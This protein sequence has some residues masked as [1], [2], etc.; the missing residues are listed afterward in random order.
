ML[1]Y[2]LC[3]LDMA[4]AKRGRGAAAPAEAA[5][6]TDEPPARVEGERKGEDACS[7]SV[8]S[9]HWKAMYVQILQRAVLSGLLDPA[10][11]PNVA[12]SE[13]TNKTAET[14]DKEDEEKEREQEAQAR[15]ATV[16]SSWRDQFPGLYTLLSAAVSSTLYVFV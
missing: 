1:L 5:E 16:V 4:V 6:M 14:E 8:H 3:G 2:T 9:G 13:E 10:F 7:V 12:R 15:A 11:G